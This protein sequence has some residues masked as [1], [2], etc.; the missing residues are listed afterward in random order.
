MEL[1]VALAIFVVSVGLL[2]YTLFMGKVTHF[3]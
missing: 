1:M 3:L 2:I